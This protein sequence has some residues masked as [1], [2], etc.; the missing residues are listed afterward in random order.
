[1]ALDH[2][3]ILCEQ[4]ELKLLNQHLQIQVAALQNFARTEVNPESGR[5]PNLHA[6]DELIQKRIVE[7]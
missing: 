5:S 7:A 2:N 1:M 4:E 3:N 6:L